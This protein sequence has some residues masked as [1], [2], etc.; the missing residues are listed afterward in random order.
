MAL[1]HN[2]FESALNFG[3]HLL[4]QDKR[5]EKEKTNLE[6][7]TTERKPCQQIIVVGENTNNG[8]KGLNPLARTPTTAKEDSI[9]LNFW[10]SPATIAL[11]RWHLFLQGKRMEK[12]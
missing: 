1:M 7:K 12:E 10:L 2:R 4:F 3:L 8:G 11:R 6:G 5:M 9:G